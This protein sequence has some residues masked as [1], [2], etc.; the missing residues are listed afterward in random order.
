MQEGL[1]YSYAKFSPKLTSK[2]NKFLMKGNKNSF[3]PVMLTAEDFAWFE[4]L[5]LSKAFN[6]SSRSGTVLKDHIYWRN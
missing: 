6:S 2:V 5:P 3:L 1:D 4:K